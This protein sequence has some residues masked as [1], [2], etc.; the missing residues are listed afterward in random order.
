MRQG[1]AAAAAQQAALAEELSRRN[2]PLHYTG[3]PLPGGGTGT[4]SSGSEKATIA[5]APLLDAA[6]IAVAL[7]PLRRC[8]ERKDVE[9]ATA[10]LAK[11]HEAGVLDTAP[12]L[13]LKA[14]TLLLE[15]RMTEAVASAS[16]AVEKN[17]E[18][19]SAWLA[20]GHLQQ[21]A[22]D[23]SSAIR[24]FL[25]AQRLDPRSAPTIYSLGM[26][27]FLLG[28]DT[29][30]DDYY[31]RA[32]RH[33]R[34]ALELDPKLDRA[35]FML[36][37]IEVV[38]SKLSEARSYVEKALALSPQNPY[39]HLQFG[40]LLARMGES[41]KALDEMRTAEK[42]DPGNP[43]SH[44]SLGENYARQHDFQAARRELE[45][46]VQLNPHLASAYYTLGSVYQRWGLKNEAETAYATFQKEKKRESE[47]E[48]DRVSAAVQGSGANL[49]NAR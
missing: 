10:E 16:A 33:F 27:F 13:E 29:N 11:V 34:F 25:E 8:V 3:E 12:Y 5:S 19:P 42:L 23:Q 15:H 49:P 1:Q 7:S 43:Q 44:L 28:Q 2:N 22:G 14:E 21:K 30:A 47:G 46:A 35:V 40:I 31:Q 48:V 39:Y 41:E 24:S 36:G 4:P 18:D 37:V 32:A 6:K 26:S 20:L 9:C 38:E 17:R 45:K